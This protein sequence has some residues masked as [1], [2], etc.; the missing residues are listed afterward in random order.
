MR[1]RQKKHLVKTTLLFLGA[2]FVGALFLHHQTDDAMNIENNRSQCKG[3]WCEAPAEQPGGLA[4][5]LNHRADNSRELDEK[6]RFQDE[7]RKEIAGHKE[8]DY[9]AR[10]KRI[11]DDFRPVNDADN[12]INVKQSKNDAGKLL[13]ESR[14]KVRSKKEKE[15]SGGQ[16]GGAAVNRDSG[17]GKPAQVGKFCI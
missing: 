16:R 10:V 11:V 12:S 17:E 9:E 14:D 5:V 15:E 1:Y 4:P 3:P 6:V 7:P 8:D 2:C 13:D